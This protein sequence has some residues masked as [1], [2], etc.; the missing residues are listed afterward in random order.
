M[1]MSPYLKDEQPFLCSKICP[2]ELTGSTIVLSMWM[3]I[4]VAQGLVSAPEPMIEM[5]LD[6]I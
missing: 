1:M 2:Q 4:S 6:Q 3:G 5:P